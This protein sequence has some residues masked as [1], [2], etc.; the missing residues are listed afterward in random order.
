MTESIVQRTTRLEKARGRDMQLLLEAVLADNAA[1]RADIATLIANSEA[2]TTALDTAM[3]VLI[4]KMNLDAGI[5]DA[6]YVA[7]LT[8]MAATAATSTTPNLIS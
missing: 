8:A 5:T 4:A 7:S 1:L 6:N 3:D 2:N